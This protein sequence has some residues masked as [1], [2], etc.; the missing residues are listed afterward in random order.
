MLNK[1]NSKPLPSQFVLTPE[2]RTALLEAKLERAEAHAKA[3]LEVAKK[4]AKR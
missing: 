2:Q 4:L 1:T 3:L